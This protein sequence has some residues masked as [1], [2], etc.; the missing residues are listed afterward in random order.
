MNST[1]NYEKV[2]FAEP[3]QCPEC[4]LHTHELSRMENSDGYKVAM[5]C[6][7]CYEDYEIE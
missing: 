6:D 7:A 4:G 2:Y 3:I 1:D 5:I